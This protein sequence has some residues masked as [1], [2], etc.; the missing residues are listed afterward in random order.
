MSKP[1]NILLVILDTVRNDA[2]DSSFEDSGRCYR[3]ATAIAAAPW[4]LPSCTSIITGRAPVDHDHYWPRPRLARNA[5]LETLPRE[6]RKTGLVNNTAIDRESGIGNG[7]DRWRTDLDHDHPFEQVLPMIT[8]SRRRPQFIV[9]HSN[10]AHDYYKPT[11]DRYLSPELRSA[12]PRFLRGRV[13]TW[14]NIDPDERAEVVATYGACV[15]QV[16]RQ[17]SAVLEAVRHRDDFVTAITADHGEGFEPDLARV[18]HGG[19]LH[20]DVLRVPLFFDLPSSLSSSVRERLS[21]S[22]GSQVLSGAD[23]LPTLFDLAGHRAVNGPDDIDGRSALGSTSRTLISQDRRYLYLKDRF[24][25]NYNGRQ[26][27]MTEEDRERNRQFA[28]L[29]V[30]PPTMRSF[31]RYP[32]KCIVTSLHLKTDGDPAAHRPTFAALGNSLIGSPVL[33]VNG[34]HLLGFERFDL[35]SDP[36]EE[37]NLLDPESGGLASLQASPLAASISM[38]IAGRGDVDLTALLD[39]SQLLGTSAE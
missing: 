37:H 4:T 19:R 35:S 11:S 30:E 26:K 15:R 6:Y 33:A 16:T 32:D 28:E 17:V 38:P 27:N 7:F 23:V 25:V 24:R 34:D 9:L 31:L 20:Q 12:S 3:A 29:L 36:T 14:Q 22:L 1:L 10:I 13:I 5:L 2:L 39:G 21:D 18:H 8:R